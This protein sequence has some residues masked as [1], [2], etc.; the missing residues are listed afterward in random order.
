MLEEISSIPQLEKLFKIP[1]KG[2]MS[3][4]DFMVVR[5][6]DKKYGI[7]RMTNHVGGLQFEY[8]IL[9]DAEEETD[10]DE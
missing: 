1:I 3:G 10:W 6:E 5:M 7:T 4:P 8:I 9:D 2:G